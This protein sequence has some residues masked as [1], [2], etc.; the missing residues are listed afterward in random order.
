MSKDFQLTVSNKWDFYPVDLIVNN[1]VFD[2]PELRRQK[3]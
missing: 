1:Y 3:W 2:T